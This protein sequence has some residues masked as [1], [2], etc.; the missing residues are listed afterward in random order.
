MFKK[1]LLSEKFFLV[2]FYNSNFL[3]EIV[4]KTDF[5]SVKGDKLVVGTRGEGLGFTEDRNYVKKARECFS[6]YH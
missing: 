2:Y 5:L 4:E 1:L 3:G 6:I